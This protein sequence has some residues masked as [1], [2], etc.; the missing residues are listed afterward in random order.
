MSHPYVYILL[1]GELKMSGGK[2]AAQTAHALANLQRYH[3]D[4]LDVFNGSTRRTVIVLEA[5]NQQQMDNLRY[6][7][8]EL[9]VP[10]A[11][12]VDEGVNEVTPYSLTAMAV[13]PVEWN[14]Y[15]TRETLAPFPLY[16]SRARRWFGL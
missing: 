4:R 2:A 11:D 15:V 12:Y 5:K 14:D 16:T 1:N 7:L 8:E 10:V 13:G 6:Y 9:D 3:G